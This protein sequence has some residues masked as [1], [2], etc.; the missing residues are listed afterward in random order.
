MELFVGGLQPFV[1]D[2]GVYLSRVD[3]A[4]TEHHLNRPQVRA[5]LYQ[6][7]GE[8]VAQHVRG[9]M[10]Q[11]RR[12][13]IS[14]N[15]PPKFLAGDGVS[16]RLDEKHVGMFPLQQPL[17]D[18]EIAYQEIDGGFPN[19]NSPL[20]TSLP[21]TTQRSGLKLHIRKPEADK[22]GGS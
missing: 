1:R 22:F 6:R 18:G 14:R 11:R 8:A 13:A 2:V 15:Y 4:V 20:L 5:V 16:V 10:A 12:F 7:R 19:R 21:E 3:V 9:D 17:P